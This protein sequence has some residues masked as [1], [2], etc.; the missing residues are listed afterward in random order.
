MHEMSLCEGI[1]QIIEDQARTNHFSS[2]RRVRLE[3]GRFAGVEVDALRFGFDVVMKGSVAENAIL[4]IVELPGRAFC[5]DC[6]ETVA[7]ADRLS[8]CPSCGGGKL[9]PSGGD[10]MRIKDLEV[11]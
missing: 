2:V 3:I 11:V 9:A 5:F 8:P 4:D 10:E 7:V 6:A 1:L